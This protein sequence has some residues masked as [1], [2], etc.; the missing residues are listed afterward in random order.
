MS[1]L[2]CVLNRSRGT[3]VAIPVPRS[4]W[5]SVGPPHRP[6]PASHSA[7]VGLFLRSGRLPPLRSPGWCTPQ[8][9]LFR[10]SASGLK[11]VLLPA[12]TASDRRQ[13]TPFLSN[14]RRI[15]QIWLASR[16]RN[17]AL[18]SLHCFEFTKLI[19]HLQ[20]TPSSLLER[21]EL[22]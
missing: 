1:Q 5:V 7:A 8:W 15:T 9:P 2:E 19:Q 12:L 21:V 18:R 4:L 13:Q 16:F 17:A 20:V 11:V 14:T 10:S 6:P 22:Q 3:P